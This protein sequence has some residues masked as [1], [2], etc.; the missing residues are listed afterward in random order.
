MRLL[1]LQPLQYIP[2]TFELGRDVY[3]LGTALGA[4]TAVGASGRGSP[5]AEVTLSAA[6]FFD[7]F[8]KPPNVVAQIHLEHAVDTYPRR[9]AVTVVA[10]RAVEVV[11][12]AQ[13]VCLC[14]K[15]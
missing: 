12:P 2:N 1:D 13:L 14:D 10:G 15:R 9:A 11:E 5:H 4:L 8:G 3:L 7:R 6:A